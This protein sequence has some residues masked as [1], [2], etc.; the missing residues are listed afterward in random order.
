[1]IRDRMTQVRP[2]DVTGQVCPEGLPRASL[3]EG[4]MTIPPCQEV[5]RVDTS[6]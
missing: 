5:T 3:D 2:E 6:L 1:M 4:E